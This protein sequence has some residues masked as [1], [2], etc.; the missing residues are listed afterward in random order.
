LLYVQNT[1]FGC[2]KKCIPPVVM[3]Y[4]ARPKDPGA[5]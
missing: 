4:S 2:I 5:L 1:T 3:L